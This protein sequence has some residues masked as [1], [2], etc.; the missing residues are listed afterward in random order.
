MDKD[1]MSEKQQEILTEI[2]IVFL[3]A[4]MS[5]GFGLLAWI[6]GLAVGGW[7]WTPPKPIEPVVIRRTL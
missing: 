6:S 1:N 2:M 3:C 7:L 4:A 5:I